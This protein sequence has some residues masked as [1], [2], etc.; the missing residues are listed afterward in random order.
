M[1]KYKK[2]NECLNKFAKVYRNKLFLLKIIDMKKIALLLFIG[3]IFAS[4]NDGDLIFDELNFN[5][6]VQKCDEKNIFYKLNGSEML[7]LNMT[8][9]FED[10]N[11]LILNQE[12]ET[13]ASQNMIL[14]RQYSDKAIAGSICNLIAPGYPQV[15]DEFGNT[16]GKI[17]YQRIRKIEQKVDDPR[18]TINY[19]VSF[20][21]LNMILTNGKSELKYENYNFGEFSNSKSNAIIDFSLGTLSICPNSDI[22][23][24]K[25]TQAFKILGSDI[26][27]NPETG[28]QLINLNETTKIKFYLLEQ[29][30]NANEYCDM[31]FTD[32][33]NKIT[34]EWTA[35]QGTIEVVTTANSTV[36]NPEAISGY[37][38]TYV[39]KN[40]TFTNGSDSFEITN[41]I[42]CTNNIN[43]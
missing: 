27:F 28:T 36:E 12:Y 2:S 40:A 14:Y 23:I 26:Q 8:G 18:V 25:N 7:V 3:G 38:Q 17:T 30:V 19:I 4:C 11:T 42:L 37:T 1:F 10:P 33:E 6:E 39:L 43:L 9:K 20:N 5:Q 32:P 24:Y 29:S 34:E 31:I 21:L 16:G 22:I 13:E 41:Q 15:V 35:K